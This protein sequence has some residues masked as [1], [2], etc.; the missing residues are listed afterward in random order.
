MRPKRTCS[1][2][3]DRVKRKYPSAGIVVAGMRMP[4]N[5]GQQ[6]TAEFKSIF[7]HSHSKTTPRSFRSYWKASA[8]V[9]S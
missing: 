7:P 4:P 5:M 9:P 6:Y 1:A 8:E 3:I 2:I